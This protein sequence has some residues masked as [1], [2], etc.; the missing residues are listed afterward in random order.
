MDDFGWFAFDRVP[1]LCTHKLSAVLC[2]LAG[3]LYVPQVGIINPSEMSP[4]NS[5]ELAV[6]VAVDGRRDAGRRLD[7]QLGLARVVKPPAARKRT[8]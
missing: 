1:Q 4:A 2:G 3:A 5:I 8:S 7:Q 6:W